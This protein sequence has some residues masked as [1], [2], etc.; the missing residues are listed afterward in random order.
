M[1]SFIDNIFELEDIPNNFII[2]RGKYGTV[3]CVVDEKTGKKYAIKKMDRDNSHDPQNYS[4]FVNEINVL[5]QCHYP[6]ILP[7]FNYYDFESY[8]V[9]TE[10]MEKGSLNSFF[11]D[12]DKYKEL[13]EDKKFIIG[14]G[15]ALGMKYLHNK[16]ISHRD[17]K[18]DNILINDNYFPL[19]CD[20]GFS[21]FSTSESKKTSILGTPLFCAPEIP[22]HESLFTSSDILSF[23]S[24]E[25]SESSQILESSESLKNQTLQ[26][27]DAKKADVYSF[28]VVLL[29]LS[30]QS[31]RNVINFIVSNNRLEIYSLLESIHNPIIHNLIKECC[32]QNPDNRPDFNQI[33]EMMK[34]LFENKLQNNQFYQDFN[35]FIEE[36]H[37]K[38]DI[39]NPIYFLLN[40]FQKTILFLKITQLKTMLKLP[41]NI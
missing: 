32:D 41:K 14:Y 8:Q 37:S 17:L 28:G 22:L 30:L 20:F 38:N 33:V 2:G 5:A 35:K 4:N 25:T 26:Q 7:L 31:Y 24:S 9:I 27:Y 16:N 10:Y 1:D 13:N 15:T 12:P 39:I 19:I 29:C 6:T 21:T 3:Y 23:S 11:A 40:C 36:D 34:P 18:L